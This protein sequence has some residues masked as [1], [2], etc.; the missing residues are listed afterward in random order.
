MWKD[1]ETTID[2]LDYDYLV[3]TLNKIILNKELSPS[4]IGVYGDWGS[5]KSSLLNISQEILNKEK[6][7]LCISFNAWL[8]ESYED[9]KTALMNN[10]LA[11]IE[12]KTTLTSEGKNL[13]KKLYSNIDF[14]KLA[15]K[16]VKYGLDFFLTGGIGA[17]TELGVG[18]LK[19]IIE[20]VAKDK[21][22]SISEEDLEKS[23]NESVGRRNIFWNLTTTIKS[24]HSDF[25]DLLEDTKLRTVVIYI[26]ELDRCSPDTIL[27]VLEAIRLFLFTDRTSFV[28]GAD[29]RHISYAVKR[30][31]EEIEGN[32]I[33]IGKEYLEKLIQ[34]PI[35]IPRLNQS[36]VEQYIIYLFM[37]LRLSEDELNKV[38]KHFRE[39]RNKDYLNFTIGFEAL[40]KIDDEI[41]SKVKNDINLAKQISLVLSNGLNGNPRQCKRFLNTLMMRMEMAKYRNTDIK[42]EILSKLMMLEYFKVNFFKKLAILQYANEGKPT[43]LIH[44]EEG[45]W[46]AVNV[47]KL[48]K[49]DQWILDF[50][51]KEPSLADVDLRPYFYFVRESITTSVNVGMK[52]S[53]VAN[54]ILKNLVDGS[55]VNRNN[56]IKHSSNVNDAEANLILEEIQSKIIGNSGI[57]N[58]LFKS[59]LEWGASRESLHISTISFISSLDSN[60][61]KMGHIPTIEKF[62]TDARKEAQMSDIIERIKK[63]NPKLKAVIEEMKGE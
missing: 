28:I 61:F 52:L 1:S 51:S 36:N 40:S 32:Q 31:F 25:K 53:D 43:E 57:D 60:D 46:D 35:R 11:E 50:F 39:L 6:E 49:D 34:Y 29:E 9:S 59:L 13:L 38:L 4:T 55:M 21:V 16:G 23:I 24:F 37:Q 30:K 2:Y 14:M 27:D 15:S 20:T 12:S 10:I 58:N 5:G 48:W 41:A 3:H 17:T 54:N 18:G 19:K 45:E 33:D 7:V 44:I 26:D 22:S 63:E 42:I 8:F 62:I 56:A 47:L